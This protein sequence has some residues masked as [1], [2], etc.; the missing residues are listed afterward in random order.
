MA[1]LGRAPADE[2][3]AAQLVQRRHERGLSDDPSA[4][5]R[6]HLL[7][8]AVAPNDER[9]APFA[10]PA[11]IHAIRRWPLTNLSNIENSA[12]GSAPILAKSL[13]RAGEGPIELGLI[14]DCLR[15][16]RL[17]GD[18]LA[19]GHVAA[20]QLRPELLNVIVKRNHRPLL[21]C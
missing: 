5:F 8:R 4:I 20:P 1:A 21:L 11:D 6:D 12:H 19:A 3:L 7:A 10:R 14:G 13:E 9:I 15:K 2:M 17:H 16:L 18:T